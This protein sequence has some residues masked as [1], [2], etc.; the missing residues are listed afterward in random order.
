VKPWRCRNCHEWNAAE[1]K[2]CSTCRARRERVV[3]AEDPET[4]A[5]LTRLCVA[6]PGLAGVFAD[7]A[8]AM[9]SYAA[10]NEIAIDSIQP[11]MICTP[12]GKVIFELGGEAR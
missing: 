8:R 10:E 1:A 5:R 3:V 6:I 9:R 12:S 2:R 4:A 11:E 7:L